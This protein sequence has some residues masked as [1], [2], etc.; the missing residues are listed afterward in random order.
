MDAANNVSAAVANDHCRWSLPLTPGRTYRFRVWTARG[1][2]AISDP[3]TNSSIIEPAFDADLFGV[4]TLP[5]EKSLEIK[6]NNDALVEY[7]PTLVGRSG[8]LSASLMNSFQL[9]K[10]VN[11]LATTGG[12]V[13]DPLISGACYSI[14]VYATAFGIVSR[15][16][17]RYR[18]R[19][20]PAG[21]A[22]SFA[23]ATASTAMLNVK[24][25]SPPWILDPSCRLVITVRDD[26]NHT[27]LNKT[28]ITGQS[29]AASG[30]SQASDWTSYIFVT[31]L[32]PFSRY[33]VVGA[34]VCG[35][36]GEECEVQR[37]TLNPMKFETGQGSKWFRLH[38]RNLGV[39]K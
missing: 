28:V 4:T 33:D 31:N 32:K 6:W 21:V 23:N 10:M 38:C 14:Q 7:W 1:T 25:D 5:Q 3:Y 2:F 34:H 12:I 26:G 36:E 30:G 8:N 17:T 24:T 11:P 39:L 13:F 20:D 22:V 37:R 15:N 9:T 18:V 35:N 29:V 19:L 27:V 16:R